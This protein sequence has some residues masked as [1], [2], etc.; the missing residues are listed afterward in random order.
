MASQTYTLTFSR[1]VGEFTSNQKDLLGSGQDPYVVF[2]AGGNKAQTKVRCVSHRAT[3]SLE[4]PGY[5]R[6][7][8]EAI[9]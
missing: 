9:P 4:H 2:Q 6:S 3:S 7:L 1:L 5:I 8:H